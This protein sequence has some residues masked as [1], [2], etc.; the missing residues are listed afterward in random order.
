MVVAVLGPRGMR[1]VVNAAD[2]PSP[3]RDA[4]RAAGLSQVVLAERAGLSVTIIS[5]VERAPGLLSVRVAEALSRA[6][7]VHLEPRRATRSTL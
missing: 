1:G 3:V 5:T 4:R 2:R 6:L 7:G